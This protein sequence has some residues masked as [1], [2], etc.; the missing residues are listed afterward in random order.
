MSAIKPHALAL[1]YIGSATFLMKCSQTE[2][3]FVFQAGEI[4]ITP[5]FRH[6][7]FKY[8]GYIATHMQSFKV[9]DYVE[10]RLY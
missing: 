7:S 6:T 1:M 3:R 5:R 9:C 10:Y 2:R 8:P 4:L